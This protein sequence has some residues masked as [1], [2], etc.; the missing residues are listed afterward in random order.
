MVILAYFCFYWQCSISSRT[1][2]RLFLGQVPWWQALSSDP[3]RQHPLGNFRSWWHV[4]T[5]S[6]AWC[7]GPGGWWPPPRPEASR[8]LVGWC[9]PCRWPRPL[10]QGRTRLRCCGKEVSD[11]YK[12]QSAFSLIFYHNKYVCKEISGGLLFCS[13]KQTKKNH[14][15]I[16][17]QSSGWFEMSHSK[18]PWDHYKQH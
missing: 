10:T 14:H 3:R 18:I 5:R 8:S 9:T 13:N 16:S 7:L 1:I 11:H 12:S 6:R 2:C 15:H 4:P 17:N